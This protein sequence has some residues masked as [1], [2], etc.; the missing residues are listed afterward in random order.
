MHIVLSKENVKQM[1][2]SELFDLLNEVEVAI[3][4]LKHKQRH[5]T[6]YLTQLNFELI[7]REVL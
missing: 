1:S 7:R 5:L 4:D 6:E 2:N 3:D